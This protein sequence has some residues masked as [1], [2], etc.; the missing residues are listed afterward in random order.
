M[1]D[2]DNFCGIRPQE[3]G[4]TNVKE[5]TVWELKQ[6]ADSH[7]DYQLIDVREP[8]E[9]DIVNLGGELIPL[10]TVEESIDKIRSDKKVVIHCRSGVRSA[11]AI[12]ALERKFGFSNLYNLKGGVLAWADEVDKSLPKY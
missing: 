1:I 11:K 7:A 5:I 9:Y 2:Y 4:K 6:L 8:Y 10:K 3:N 12:E